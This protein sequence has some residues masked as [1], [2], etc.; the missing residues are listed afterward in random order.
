MVNATDV[1]PSVCQ[2]VVITASEPLSG[3][4]QLSFNGETTP[5]INAAA[6]AEEVRFALESLAGITTAAVSRDFAVRA[7]DANS[8]D[9]GL[10]VT[11]GSQTATCSTG[12]DEERVYD[13]PSAVL[14]VNARWTGHIISRY[15]L[16]IRRSWCWGDKCCYPYHR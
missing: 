14:L 16:G 7:V 11:F 8:G 12:G 2:R 6:S 13:G 15:I 10:D 4:F 9:G 3:T 5:A 1:F